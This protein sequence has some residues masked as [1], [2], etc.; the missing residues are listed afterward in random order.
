MCLG[1]SRDIDVRSTTA[2]P[3]DPGA[4]HFTPL[5]NDFWAR[6]PGGKTEVK[7]FWLRLDI[8]NPI[9]LYI[10]KREGREGRGG[11]IIIVRGYPTRSTPHCSHALR[12]ARRLA[13]ASSRGRGRDRSVDRQCRDGRVLEPDGCHSQRWLATLVHP[14]AVDVLVRLVDSSTQTEDEGVGL[15]GADRF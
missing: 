6:C 15:T 1:C 12:G 13:A 3:W 7:T 9:H 11:S 14:D 8:N 4:C 2:D 5:L 10:K